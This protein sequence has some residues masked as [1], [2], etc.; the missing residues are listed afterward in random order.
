MS[1]PNK[2]EFSLRCGISVYKWNLHLHSTA[3]SAA[4]GSYP[5]PLPLPRFRSPEVT[6][7]AFSFSF[8]H[9]PLPLPRFRS[10]EVTGVALLLLLPA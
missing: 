2:T 3:E 1:N 6:G 8:R 4:Y 10:P 9:E 7:V 5:E